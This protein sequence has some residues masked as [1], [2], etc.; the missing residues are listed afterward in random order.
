MHVTFPC[1]VRIRI[2]S[3]SVPYCLEPLISHHALFAAGSRQQAAL[4]N[5]RLLEYGLHAWPCS[6]RM[7]IGV[8]PL[9][10][11]NT[12]PN[13]SAISEPAAV[14]PVCLLLPAC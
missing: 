4:D 10:R 3:Q 9:T 5:L 8:P 14:E 7:I 6:K 13:V 11:T 1:P 12:A 2:Y